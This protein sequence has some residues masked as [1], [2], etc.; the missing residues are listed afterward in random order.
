MQ[1]KAW[2]L[3]SPPATTFKCMKSETSASISEQLLHLNEELRV[4]IL[5]HRL[6]A[7]GGKLHHLQNFKW[8][9]GRNMKETI[10][11]VP[12]QVPLDSFRTMPL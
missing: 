4:G 11:P 8:D 5:A 9:D 12:R 2:C 6:H 10:K 7:I 3:V 1:S